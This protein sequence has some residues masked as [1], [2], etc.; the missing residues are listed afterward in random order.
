MGDICDTN[1][2][3]RFLRSTEGKAK[4]AQVREFLMERV[5]IDVSFQNDVSGVSIDLLLDD[6]AH[7]CVNW[8][9]VD[10]LREEFVGAIEREYYVDYPGRKPK[11]V[12]IK[13]ACNQKGLPKVE[14]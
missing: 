3:E 10:D 6:G 4:M 2:I 12:L 7:F 14:R 8:A 13:E 9:G 5:I 1:D 11:S